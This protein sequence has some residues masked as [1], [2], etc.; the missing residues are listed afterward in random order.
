MIACHLDRNS[1]SAFWP[2]LCGALCAA[3]LSGCADFRAPEYQRP[4]APGKS[5]WSQP[6]GAAVSAADT[7]TPDWWRE[8]GDPYLD[9]L[10][11]AAIAGNFDL[12]VLAARIQVASTEIAAVEAGALPTANLGA[13]ADFEKT[14]QRK[15][16][17]TYTVA[18]QLSWEI[19][20]WGKVAK[21]VQ[22]QT[23]EWRATE[24]DWRAGYLKLI[25][26]V[27][28]T[29]F[30][31]LQFDEQIDQQQKALAKNRQILAIYE[32]QYANGVVGQTQVLQQRAEV[33]RQ[34]KELLELRRSRNV[35]NNALATL[36]GVPAGEFH[37]P[38]GYLEERVRLPLVPPGLPS[39]LLARRPDV[40]AAEYR[41]LEAV[42]LVGQARL[43][44][45]P[46]IGMTGRAGTASLSPADLFKSFTLSFLPSI[47]LPLF[48]PNIKAQIKI[49]EAQTKVAEEQYRSTVL[50]AYEEVESTLVNLGAHREQRTQL[51]QQ[52]D[53]L[54]AAA[55]QVEA[56]LKEGLVSQLEV[57]EAERQLL[58]AE[59][60]LLLNQ[61]EI[62]SDTVTIYKALGGGWP[63]V[64]V[65]NQS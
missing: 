23:A 11:N 60:D 21:G 3:L 37:V 54:R 17:Q 49:S 39:Q 41:V 12:K 7:I 59:L 14:T 31:I 42:D 35:A 32:A 64:N 52:T 2:S 25:A 58:A 57:F 33:N 61:Q 8:F 55:A 4:D 26:S 53:S 1:Q 62:L 20:I 44:Q 50:A 10:V 22:G 34:T 45:L 65:R 43:A 56:Q 63:T 18:G 30:Q 6:A 15:S 28:T 38:H 13:G 46:S 51:L 29:Y 24:A 16:T 36:T 19:D 27:S 9:T 5:S 47:N 40:I 48:D